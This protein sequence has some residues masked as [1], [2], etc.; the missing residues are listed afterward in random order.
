VVQGREERSVDPE[1]L[2]ATHR[3]V[4][5]HAPSVRTKVEEGGGLYERRKEGGGGFSER[6]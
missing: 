2:S 4:A 1:W 3:L 5:A 6:S